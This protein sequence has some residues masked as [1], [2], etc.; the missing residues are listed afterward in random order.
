M[1][2]SCL[3]GVISTR[4]LWFVE[5]SIC[6]KHHAA[7][8]TYILYVTEYSKNQYYRCLIVIII[9]MIIMAVFIIYRVLII[10]QT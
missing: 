5:S 4:V 6:A 3:H 9:I 7:C 8:F 10:C 2:A 1:C